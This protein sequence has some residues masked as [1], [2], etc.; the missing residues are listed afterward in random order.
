M[1]RKANSWWQLRV[2][3][4]AAAVLAVVVA[5]PATRGTATRLV[6]RSVG[7]LAS[8]GGLRVQGARIVDAS[9]QPVLLHGVNYSGSESSCVA[10]SGIFAGP[11]NQAMVDAI[12]SWHANSVRLPLNEDCWLGINGVSPALGGASYREAIRGFV[13]RLHA[14]GLIAV[15]DLRWTAPGSKPANGLLPMPDADHA[16]AF[17]RSVAATFKDDTRVVFD[18]FA[19]PFDV[20]WPCWRDGGAACSALDYRAAGM[21]A[22]VDTIRGAGATQPIALAGLDRGNDLSQWL[23]H[24]PQDKLDALVAELGAFGDG[25]CRDVACW[26][27]AAAPVA[28]QVPVVAGALAESSTGSACGGSFIERFMGWADV[29]QVGYEA[30]TWNTPGNCSSLISDFGGSAT[31]GC[32]RAF[33]DH[34]LALAG[35]PVGSAPAPAVPVT[36]PPTVPVADRAPAVSRTVP[37]VASKAVP[38]LTQPGQRV[39]FDD[40]ERD[41]LDGALPAGWL[42]GDDSPVSVALDG[43]HVLSYRSHAGRVLAAGSVWTDYAVS[44]DVRPA[45]I[46]VGD[47]GVAGRYVDANAYYACTVHDGAGLELWR[48]W[49]GSRQKLDGQ[50]AAVSG[51]AG[52]HSVRLEMR[53]SQ[54]TCSLDGVTLLHATDGSVPAGRLGLVSLGALPSE[55]DNVT[56]TALG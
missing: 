55:F 33:H 16:L 41:P 48:M 5:I 40:F 47:I 45:L 32:G 44:A 39:F 30:W 38:V 8:Q 2:V 4:A 15:L 52:F 10:G 25:A 43:S 24:E 56:A 11:S 23:V 53:G 35:R 34:L 17:W 14:S 9:G 27:A 12:A 21:Q 42:Q 36:V 29:H 22:I 1:V 51:A 6:S 37:G 46:A 20:S 28:R 13:A 50:L 31:S 26:E 54:L 18:A 3:I 7:Q 49:N 19:E